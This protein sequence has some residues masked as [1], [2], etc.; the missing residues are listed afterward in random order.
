MIVAFHTLGCKLNQYETESLAEAFRSQGFDVGGGDRRAGLYIVNTCT[1]TSKSE[2]KARRII[3]GFAQEDA[4]VIATGCYAEVDAPALARL[5]DNVVV[6]PQRLKGIIH[7]L[8]SFLNSLPAFHEL[9][10]AVR[11]RHMA[12]FVA[13]YQDRPNRRFEYQVSSFSF[14]SRAFLKI[15][16]GC[17]YGCSY[18]RIPQARGPSVCLAPEVVVRRFEDLAAGGYREIVLTGVNIGAYRSGGCDLG[19]LLEQLLGLHLPPRIRLSS[20]EPERI[21]ENLVRIL[22]HGQICPHF[23]IPVQS[24]SDRILAAMKRRYGA[25]RVIRSASLLRSARPGAFVAADLIVGFPGEGREDFEA[26]RRL[27]GRIEPA[28]L[29]VFPFSP[30]PGTAAFEMQPQV[31]AGVKKNRVRDLIELSDRRL[32]EYSTS[33]LGRTVE[34]VLEGGH[35]PDGYAQGVSENYLK[36]EISHVPREDF[37]ANSVVACRIERSGKP[38]RARFLEYCA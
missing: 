6:I 37:R 27:I 22:S 5:A 12:R 24:G 23:H 16:D 3:R 21:D 35:P 38:C 31:A 34:A 8:P 15:Q 32:E 17:D 11:K 19:G 10:P 7:K 20:L 33:W 4:V 1:V 29:H 9:D 36:L 2:Q 18:C 26:T 30:R 28:R 13:A 14:H 25:E